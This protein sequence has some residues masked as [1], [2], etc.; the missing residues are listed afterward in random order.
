MLG[1][2]WREAAGAAL[3]GLVVGAIALPGNRTARTQSM[4][5]PAVA[6]AASFCAAALVE[7][8]LKASPDV[9]TLA[10]LVRFSPA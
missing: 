8:G 7:L 3:V 4:V 10:A 6:V 9:V 5:A 1:G 2:G